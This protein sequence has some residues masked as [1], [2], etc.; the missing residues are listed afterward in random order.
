M[1]WGTPEDLEE[2]KLWS[3]AFKALLIKQNS[4]SN[5]KGS[6]VLTMAGKGQRF[7][8]AGYK[9]KKP[10]INVSNKP[11][12]IRAIN[13]MPSTEEKYVIVQGDKFLLNEVNNEI[14]LIVNNK[15]Y[16]VRNLINPTDGQAISCV[17]GLKNDALRNPIT[18]T[19]CDHACLYDKEI[20]LNYLEDKSVDIIVWGY[21]K[22]ANAIRNPKM[23][24]WINE[25]SN[26]IKNI[27]VKKALNDPSN[28]PVVVGTFTFKNYNILK[29]SINS[30]VKRNFKVN[31]EFYIDSAINDA[32]LLGYKCMF[33]EID[34]YFCWGTPNELK[35]FE[36]WQSCFSKW[37]SHSYN[38][39]DDKW[40]NK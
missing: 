1:Q 16:K 18:V 11:M 2:Y 27:S 36:Y 30:L 5:P 32:I 39:K 22:H 20:L 34:H 28:D 19:A 12:F 33:F 31:G 17:K 3:K 7:L 23:Y 35:T 37:K 4:I 25:K 15:G 21:R 6:L 8:D 13:S 10:F 26:I 14:K 38:I 24:G 29:N 40:I 9:R